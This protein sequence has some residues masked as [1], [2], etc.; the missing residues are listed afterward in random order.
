[1][2]PTEQLK[3]E[4]E[5]IK[6]MLRILEKARARLESTGEVNTGHLNQ[7]L[8][9]IKVFVDKCHHGKEEALLFPAMEEAGIPR[10]GG[11]IGIMLAEHEMGRSYVKG[12]SEAFD[13]YKASD[14]TSSSK[15]IKNAHDY[16]TLL[17]A[18]IDK[19]NTILFPIADSHLPEKK[20]QE[21]IAAFEKLE[22]EE[23]GIGTHE[24]FHDLLHHLKE[25]YLA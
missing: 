11:P 4:H 16:I 6:V 7:I 3:A 24:K 21:L 23:I 25:I 22:I 5:G 17:T 8:E 10:K 19:E 9:F 12:M 1:M 20:Q 13:R 14:R 15:L 2:K 18:H